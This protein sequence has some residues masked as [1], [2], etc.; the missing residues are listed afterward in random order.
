MP[1]TP[2]TLGMGSMEI[3]ECSGST[4]KRSPSL[5]K[6]TPKRK[7]SIK[8]ELS[9]P[10]PMLTPMASPSPSDTEKNAVPDSDQAWPA[11]ARSVLD[12]SRRICREVT[13]RSQLGHDLT[14]LQSQ[15]SKNDLADA[16]EFVRL[17]LNLLVDSTLSPVKRSPTSA[18]GTQGNESLELQLVRKIYT[19]TEST[20]TGMVPEVLSPFKRV[21]MKI[22][23]IAIKEDELESNASL[24]PALQLFTEPIPSIPDSTTTTDTTAEDEPTPKRKTRSR[25][26]FPLVTPQKTD[27]RPTKKSSDDS[28]VD[29]PATPSRVLRKR[30]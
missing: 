25:A 20:L 15:L 26:T 12:I 17:F 30:N 18:L 19:A 23:S 28:S 2:S 29:S 13:N 11:L 6:T 24:P 7:S 21:L 3:D 1:T 9:E 4:V 5:A 22:N 10:I 27:K 8:S 14:K 16:T